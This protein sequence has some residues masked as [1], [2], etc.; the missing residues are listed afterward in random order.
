MEKDMVE[1]CL[2]DVEEEIIQFKVE[3]SMQKSG[4]DLC[5]VGCYLT[6]SVVHFPAMKNTMANLWHPLEGIQMHGDKFCRKRINIGTKEVKYGWDMSLKAQPRRAMITP[7]VW[8]REDNDG[9]NFR[10]FMGRQ[11][12]GRSVVFI[13]ETKL[14][15]TRME[16]VRRRCG[17]YNGI[18][19]LAL[20]TRSGISLGWKGDLSISLRSYSINHIDVDIEGDGDEPKWRLIGFH[21]ALEARE[22]SGI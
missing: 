6:A 11:T 10:D 12:V 1:L 5:L 21:G 8:L 15:S 17:F 20:D 22:K 14:D 4:Y 7:S 16:R 9:G 13:M 2:D 3:R 19:V 18:D